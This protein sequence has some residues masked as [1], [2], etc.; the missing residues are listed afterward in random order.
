MKKVVYNILT[1]I[2]DSQYCPEWLAWK[3]DDIRYADFFDDVYGDEDL[4]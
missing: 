1:D 3:I 4:L 2:R